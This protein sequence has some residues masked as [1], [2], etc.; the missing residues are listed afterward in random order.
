LRLATRALELASALGD[1]LLLR[2]ATLHLS[3]V[4]WAHRNL[5]EA[6]TLLEG[7]YREWHQQDEPW[8]AQILYGLS[9]I[10]LA[11]GRWELAAAHAAHAR[12]IK[13][14]YGLEE[15]PDYLAIAWIAVH[16]GQLDFARDQSERAL[17]LA[18]EHFA[19]RPPIHLSV[20]GLA[21]LWAGDA[22]AAARWFDEAE[23][24]AA[25]LDWREPTQRPWSADYA[26]ALLE[27]GRL[28]DAVRLVDR[29]EADASRLGRDWVL[30]DLAR[31]RG[32]VAAAR[33]DIGEASVLLEAAVAQHEAV[34]DRFGRARALLALGVVAR[35][36][37]RKRAAR[38]AIAAALG[39]FQDL[40][41]AT[42]VERAVRELGTIGGRTRE[43]G[44][45]AAERR[46]ADLVAVGRTNREVAAELFL[47][48]RT[49]ASHLTHIYAKLGVRS[50]TEL[51]R[52]LPIHEPT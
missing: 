10:E 1:P 36:A 12:E 31:C 50:R 13:T 45:T 4:H 17:L 43:E 5:D 47:A 2:H 41:A 37:R 35:R 18:R 42:W 28:D 22:R 27:L 8:S 16:R 39:G 46:V 44:L 51:A 6:R 15:P 23:E 40:G 30:A 52:R 26:E 9:W 3:S 25:R 33:G 19:F 34:G 29:M 7:L 20:L 49:V 14:Q 24:Q 21:A 32:L 48:E 38:N 11:G